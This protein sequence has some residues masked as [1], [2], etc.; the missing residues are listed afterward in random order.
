MLRIIGG[1]INMVCI[2]GVDIFCDK[3][4]VVLFIYIYGIGNI[5]VKKILVDVGVFEDVCVCEL[6]NE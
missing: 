4:V 3:C 1:V 6:M 5:I 2:V